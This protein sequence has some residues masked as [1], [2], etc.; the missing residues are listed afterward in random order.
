MYAVADAGIQQ[1]ADKSHP[2]QFHDTCRQALL[3]NIA[4]LLLSDVRKNNRL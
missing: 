3:L 1:A 4:F 2:V